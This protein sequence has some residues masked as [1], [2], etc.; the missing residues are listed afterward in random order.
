MK[1]V[2]VELVAIV[3]KQFIHDPSIRLSVGPILHS[4]ELSYHGATPVLSVPL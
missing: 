3:H 2:I 1:L 4:L